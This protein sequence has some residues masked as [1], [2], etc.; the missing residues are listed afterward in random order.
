[1]AAALPAQA[2]SAPAAL[3][4][5]VTTGGSTL[6]PTGGSSLGTTQ[7]VESTSPNASVD[8]A[9]GQVIL[10]AA[11]QQSLNTTATQTA[12]GLQAAN[13]GLATVLGSPGQIGL[14]SPS[15]VGV[16]LAT[17]GEE[18][19][20]TIGEI[21]AAVAAAIASGNSASI[22]SSQG[23]LNIA[24]PATAGRAPGVLVASLAGGAIAQATPD[25]TPETAPVATTAVFTPTG[26]IPMVMP[27][28]G[29]PAQV[30]NAAGFL[31]A[32]FAA[33]LPPSQVSPLVDWALAGADY[34]DL[35]TL[36]NATSGLLT[37]QPQPRDAALE[38]SPTQLDSAIQAYNQVV[39]GVDEPTL[40]ALANNADFVALGRSLQ[41]L[42]SAIDL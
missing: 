35:V 40:M 30:A 11:A 39:D 14:N 5:G 42:R 1:V 2:G 28:Q 38:V 20:D 22:S 29:S 13:P 26:G 33:G 27:L 41:Q 15:P 21:A 6:L 7:A 23:T 34:G 4:N 31:A 24:A 18:E 25:A 37:P 36:F 32:A 10:T 3:L 17:G 16:N 9:T 19:D 12:A 8:P